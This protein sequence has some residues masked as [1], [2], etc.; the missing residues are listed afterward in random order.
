ME[1]QEIG[2]IVQ[3][4]RKRVRLSRE[5]LS[6]LSGVS[7]SAIYGIEKGKQ[8]VR[9]NTLMRILRALNISIHIDGPLVREY[10]ERINLAGS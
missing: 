5:R 1:M 3:Y 6:K 9:M 2:K 8:S 10:R 4:H 7:A